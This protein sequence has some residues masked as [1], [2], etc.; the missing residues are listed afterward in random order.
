MNTQKKTIVVIACGIA[1]LVIAYL[2]VHYISRCGLIQMQDNEVRSVFV[3]RNGIVMNSNDSVILS[4]VEEY[5]DEAF[6]GDNEEL[7]KKLK[8]T[9]DV[10]WQKYGKELLKGKSGSIVAIDP[11]TGEVL[12]MVSTSAFNQ[13]IMG[14][15]PPGD[16]FKQVNSLVYLSEGVI[17]PKTQYPCDGGFKYNGINISCSHHTSVE[18]SDALKTSCNGYFCC[19]YLDMM[20]DSQYG[21]TKNAFEK[22]HEYLLSLGLGRQLGIDLSNE[23]R[24]FVPDVDYYDKMYN[25]KWNALMT[26]SNAIGQGGI[27]VTPLQLANLAVIIANR[28]HYYLPHVV[29]KIRGATT[30][31]KYSIVQSTNVSRD[32]YEMVINAMQSSN[33]FYISGTAE[34][35]GKTHSACI[36]FAPIESP[37]IAISVYVENDGIDANSATSIGKKVI[38][39]YI[40]EDVK[41]AVAIDIEMNEVEAYFLHEKPIDLSDVVSGGDMVSIVGR[42]TE[43]DLIRAK[44]ISRYITSNPNRKASHGFLSIAEDYYNG[45]AIIHEV[46][47]KLGDWM[48]SIADGETVEL[49]NE[50]L[51]KISLINVNVLKDSHIRKQSQNLKDGAVQ[52]VNIA[53]AKREKHIDEVLNKRKEALRKVLDDKINIQNMADSILWSAVQRR[54]TAMAKEVCQQYKTEDKSKKMDAALYALNECN[55]FDEQCALL[56]MVARNEEFIGNDECVLIIAE[57]LMRSGHYSPLL[58]HVWTAWRSIYQFYNC[59]MSV[60]SEIPN[61]VYNE[62][63]KICYL[64]CLHCL[65]QLPKDKI[66]LTQAV[67]LAGKS[68]ILRYGEFAIGNS[69][70]MDYIENFK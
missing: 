56:L 61:E 33:T 64:A 15:Y 59:G 9:I 48:V 66:A 51:H 3:D 68:D 40:K 32:A 47:S 16:V 39:K 26:L 2:C 69:A 14:Q 62:Y 30:D 27:A 17:T 1:I 18:L 53:E 12:C 58:Y 60:Y 6:C 20:G 42:D 19:G 43:E 31:E 38:D 63:R 21:T 24:G 10:E 46:E 23:R 41:D 11:T 4:G 50:T 67:L 37:R 13:C 22:W 55:N 52:L 54:A 28:G 5:Y 44:N 36:G 65:R 45:Y 49:N 25:S 57:R 34:S 7:G 29:K 8:L 35:M 70:I